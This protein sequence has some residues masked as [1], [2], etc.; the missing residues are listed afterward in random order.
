MVLQQVQQ[1][2]QAG[3]P[4]WVIRC[5]VSSRVDVCEEENLGSVWGV[6]AGQCS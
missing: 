1:E 5:G 2:R 4:Q 3:K 6:D